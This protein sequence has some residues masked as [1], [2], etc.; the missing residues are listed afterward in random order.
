M[1][2]YTCHKIEQLLFAC[3]TWALALCYWVTF[4]HVTKSQA[5][6]IP[7]PDLNYWHWLL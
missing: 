6:E 7:P 4:Y 2:V 5:N 1:E 3:F